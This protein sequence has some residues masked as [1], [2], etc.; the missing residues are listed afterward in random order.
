MGFTSIQTNGGKDIGR[1]TAY[2][3]RN[4][5]RMGA[6]GEGGRMPVGGTTTLIQTEQSSGGWECLACGREW[7]LE[8]GTPED[9]FYN[10]CPDCGSKVTAFVVL[11]DQ[12]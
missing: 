6:V 10:Y 4:G 5:L 1:K 8:E 3:W 12:E 9:H 2:L 7:W 11:M